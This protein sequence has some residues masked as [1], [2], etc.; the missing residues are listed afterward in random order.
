VLSQTEQEVVL[1]LGD[2]RYR[3]RGWKKPLNPE[4]LKINLLVHRG[5][6]FHVD[7]LDLYSAKARANTGSK[8]RLRA[9]PGGG[10]CDV[11]ALARRRR[12][13]ALD[14]ILA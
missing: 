1:L 6:R 7:T 3:V 12:Q 13:D 9:D 4:S 2:R 11:A 14:Q 10:R 5:E 8:E